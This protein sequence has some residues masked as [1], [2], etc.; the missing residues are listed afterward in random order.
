MKDITGESITLTINGQPVESFSEDVG[1]TT[2]AAIHKPFTISLSWLDENC[3]CTEG[4]QRFAEQCGVS[5]TLDEDWDKE[6][7]ILS[8][9]GGRNTQSDLMWLAAY[10]LE[11]GHLTV[12]HTNHFVREVS[13]LV[14]P[15][16]RQH[17]TPEKYDE[18]KAV[19]EDG[20]EPVHTPTHL[21]RS[22]INT[23]RDNGNEALDQIILLKGLYS[24]IKRK[25]VEVMCEEFESAKFPQDVFNRLIT[26]LLNHAA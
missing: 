22:V 5:L 16:V 12:D 26:E 4:M 17:F 20:A 8:L 6:F 7:P 9:V 10:L 25:D 23:A 21:F 11:D 3:A 24:S 2:R 1:F 13:K 14:L 15:S 19:F 18:I